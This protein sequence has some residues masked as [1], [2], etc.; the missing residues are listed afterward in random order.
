LRSRVGFGK[1]GEEEFAMRLALLATLLIAT[2]L[3][4]AP[5]ESV[6][7][8]ATGARCAPMMPASADKRQPARVRKLGE[9]PPGK[10]LLAVVRGIEGCATLAVVRENVG[11]PGR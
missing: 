6:T 3:A 10:Q 9:M 5:P 8:A 4:A 11:M 1:S 7:P 2:P